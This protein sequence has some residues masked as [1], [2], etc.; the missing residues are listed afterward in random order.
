MSNNNGAFGCA[1]TWIALTLLGAAVA[2]GLAIR[3]GVWIAR[4]AAGV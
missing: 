1:I 3:F 4:I 2:I